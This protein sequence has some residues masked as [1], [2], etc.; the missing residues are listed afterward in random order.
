MLLT[1][2]H[3]SAL[4]KDGSL[5]TLIALDP[6]STKNHLAQMLNANTLK[7]AFAGDIAPEKAEEYV[8]KLLSRSLTSDTILKPIDEPVFTQIPIDE[9]IP[10]NREQSAVVM[11]IAGTSATRRQE[12]IAVSILRHLENGLSS[13]LFEMVREDNSLAYSVGMNIT[14][15]LKRGIIT[16][17]AKTA[18]GKKERVLELFA[19]ELERLKNHGI[20]AEEFAKAKEQAAF[21]LAGNF[22]TPVY[23]LPE[24]LLDLYYGHAPADTPEKVEKLYL[25]YTFDEFYQVFDPVFNN[26]V[27]VT[28]AAG[29][30]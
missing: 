8:S 27:P 4:G 3:P 28:V 29:N 26:A 22:S 2:G 30:I 21:S 9:D 18:K 20:T 17:H 5:E 13:R 6:A 1:S 19:Q 11:S 10:I 16:F 15:G 12:Q 14:S 23:I 24:I 25:D 7:A